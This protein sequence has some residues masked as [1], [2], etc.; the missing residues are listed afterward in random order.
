MNFLDQFSILDYFV[1]TLILII[2]IG[3]I[4]YGHTLK[5]KDGNS[6][7]ELMLMG[8]SLTTPLFVATLVATWYGGIFGVSQIAFESG[9]YNLITQ[10]A[11]WYI[12]YLIFAF[13]ILKKI[14]NYKSVTLADL[15]GDMFG[16]KSKKLSAI[17]NILN[18]VPVVYTISLGL[19]IQMLFQTSFEIS[20]VL[21]IV[22]T[23]AYSL[24][25]GFRAVVFSDI[26]Q[27]FVMISAVI[28]VLVISIATKGFA[29]LNDLPTKYYSLT[30]G[31]SILETISWGIIAIS[32]LVDPNFYQRA[33]A[34]KN[35]KVAKKGILI[36]T[37]IWIVFDISLTFGAMYAKATMPETDS[38]YGYFT[39]AFSLLPNGLKGF[40]LAGIFATILSTLDSYLFLCGSIT[41]NDLFKSSKKKFYYLGS[42]TAAI[43]A[44]I[45]A[46]SFEGNIKSVWKA[47]GSIS[48]AALLIPV[49][50][51]H[52][53][54]KKL[55]D[56]AFCITAILSSI[57][58][59]FWRLS[60]LKHHY[61]LDELYIGCLTSLVSI[62]ILKNLET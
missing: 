41:M 45:L 7:M 22:F 35:F 36:S 30:G 50:Y 56:T 58:I 59:V 55:G 11:F 24:F 19:L 53:F 15:I 14:Q 13:Y 40:F 21:G 61:S 29:P 25:G 4:I 5:P 26:I 8:R 46:I 3:A 9:L 31:H 43:C 10:G 52:I 32:T 38:T 18:L 16:P 42:I 60:G 1:F 23:L 12:S 48:S 57:M 27:F 39:Y 62:L 20:I 51:G 37:L 34:A 33:F 54:P 17:F 44:V 49:L 47:L 2:T 28:I 6:A